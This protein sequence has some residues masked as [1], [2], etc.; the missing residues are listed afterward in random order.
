DSFRMSVV[1]LFYGFQ[2]VFYYPFESLT[3]IVT[4]QNFF[5]FKVTSLTYTGNT[6]KI[7]DGFGIMN[8]N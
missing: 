1:T 8:N 3:S 7:K 2:S 5:G 4:L 6:C